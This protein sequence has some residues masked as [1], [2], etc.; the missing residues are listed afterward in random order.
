MTVWDNIELFEQ[1]IAEYCGSKYAVAVDSCTNGI[2]LSLKYIGIALPHDQY[3]EVPK[4]TYI[5]VPMMCMHAGFDVKFVDREWAGKYRLSPHNVIDSAAMFAKDMHNTGDF[6]CI[7]FHFKK[8]VSTGRGGMIL[9]DDKQAVDWLVQA[10]YDGRPSMFYNEMTT[11]PVT[12]LGYHMYMQ[13]EQAVR[14]LESFYRIKGQNIITGRSSEY[15]V[16]LS[17]LDVFKK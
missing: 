13:P 14:G 11:K 10:R 12:V 3:V 6:T 9:T 15:K 7:S 1:E 2:F 17:K 8:A 16:D 4:Y 5:S